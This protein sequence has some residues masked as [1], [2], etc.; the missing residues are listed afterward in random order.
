MTALNHSDENTQTSVEAGLPNY[1]MSA[2]IPQDLRKASRR[3]KSCPH[4][5]HTRLSSG[6]TT[7]KPDPANIEVARTA[8]VTLSEQDEDL[9]SWVVN[10]KML[11][12]DRWI[13]D[14]NQL[15]LTRRLGIIDKLPRITEDE[16]NDLNR[17]DVV[18]KFLAVSQIS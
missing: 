15:A 5:I 7:W 13:L 16:I 14:A 9:D 11:C 10:L 18:V 8:F 17:S 3:G 2:S 6:T 1:P 4:A 12:G